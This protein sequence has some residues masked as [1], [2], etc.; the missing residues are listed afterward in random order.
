[1]ICGNLY[2]AGLTPVGNPD[3]M[4]KRDIIERLKKE[5]QYSQPDIVQLLKP[6]NT[7]FYGRMCFAEVQNAIIADRQ[8]RM[9]YLVSQL[10]KI[11]LDKMYSKL[12]SGEKKAIL[13]T[14]VG[15]RRLPLSVLRK[16]KVKRKEHHKVYDWV[17]GK[18]NLTRAEER[19]RREKVNHRHSH[20]ISGKY[21]SK[22][23]K[24]TADFQ[25]SLL[26]IRK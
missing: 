13:S 8:L 25:N 7:D 16:A 21:V 18:K 19:F 17:I 12:S 22:F 6:L 14:S 1:M 3:L 4:L 2:S 15:E 26:L 11:P 24:K 9:L 10:L 23:Y 5:V 20:L